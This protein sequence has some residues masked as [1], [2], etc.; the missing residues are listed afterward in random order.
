[1]LLSK[2]LYQFL[3]LAYPR[4]FRLE[5]GPAMTQVFGDCCRDTQSLG[6]EAS[7]RFWLTIIFDVITTA[8]AERW[9]TFGKGHA[10]MKNL[11]TNIFGLLACLLVIV[12]AFFLLGYGRKHEVA[13]ILLFGHA[14][15][16]IVTAGVIS[17]LII[18]PLVMA[19]RLSPFRTALWSLLIVN[20][21]LLLL[22]T[23]I[24][25]RV[26]PQFSFA[27]VLVGYLVSFLL[28]LAIHWIWSQTKTTTEPIA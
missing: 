16:A 19:T 5:Y 2:R 7:L 8:P 23:L 18:F 11:K 17:N 6:L 14:L 22:A 4:E 25:G 27:R 20:G 9:D 12:V 26:D 3:L 10:T 13:S 21:A 15:D 1:M 28:W 24:G